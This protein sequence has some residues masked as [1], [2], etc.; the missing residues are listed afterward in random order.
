MS[1][2]PYQ[3]ARHLY[4]RPGVV[5]NLLLSQQGENH[6]PYRKLMTDYIARPEIFGMLISCVHSYREFLLS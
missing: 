1:P 6:Q 2:T 3:D 4:D 5:L